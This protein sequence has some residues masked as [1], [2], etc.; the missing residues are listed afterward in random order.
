MLHMLQ[1]WQD[2]MI[3]VV[4]VLVVLMCCLCNHLTVLSSPS[5]HLMH[6]LFT[7]LRFITLAYQELS[8]HPSHFNSFRGI[9]MNARV[10]IGK[11]ASPAVILFEG[12]HEMSWVPTLRIKSESPFKPKKDIQ[13]F[14]WISMGVSTNRS[15]W[16]LERHLGDVNLASIQLLGVVHLDENA[17][18]NG[19]MLTVV[20]TTLN[21]GHRLRYRQ[22]EHLPLQQCHQHHQQ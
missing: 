16:G 7:C 3:V 6:N 18:R 1:C 21:L 8:K 17:T 11:V 10:A 19:A 5:W 2:Q 13:F 14:P 20:E 12:K 15:R 22:R 4:S 9:L